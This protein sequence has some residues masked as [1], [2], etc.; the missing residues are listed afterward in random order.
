MKYA[1]AAGG[2]ALVLAGTASAASPIIAPHPGLPYHRQ[3][4]VVGEG[5]PLKAY[6][7]ISPSVH[8]FGDTIH[9]KLSVIADTRWV[10]PGRLR[11]CPVS[12]ACASTPPLHAARSDD[13]GRGEGRTS[14]VRAPR[15]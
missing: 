13:G 1:L 10:D 5:L 9:A 14:G 7:G 12:C 15:G 4:S 11:V 3:G 8:L 6:A 2:A